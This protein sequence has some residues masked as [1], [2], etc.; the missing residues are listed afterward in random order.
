[1]RVFTAPC[2][3]FSVVFVAFLPIFPDEDTHGR[4]SSSKGVTP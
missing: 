2:Q 4:V 1:M 3:K